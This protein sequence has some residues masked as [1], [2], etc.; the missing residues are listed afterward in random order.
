LKKYRIKF[1]LLNQEKLIEAG[2]RIKLI[3][4]KQKVLFRAER[5]NLC[6]KLHKECIPAHIE[7]LGLLRRQY[8]RLSGGDYHLLFDL[9][10]RPFRNEL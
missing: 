8:A 7:K 6:L 3:I 2:D 4:A 1:I 5:M 9:L 10:L